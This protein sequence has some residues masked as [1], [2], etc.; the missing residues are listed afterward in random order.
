MTEV[1]KCSEMKLY[2]RI[3]LFKKLVEKHTH[4]ETF[5]SNEKVFVDAFLLSAER[6]RRRECLLCVSKTITSLSYCP[7]H[8]RELLG[9]S[10][11]E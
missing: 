7:K 10:E 8:Y 1:R 6:S 3:I 9:F 11:Q 5:S 4:N 2:E